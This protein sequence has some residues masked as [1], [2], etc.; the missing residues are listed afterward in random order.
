MVL[1]VGAVLIIGGGAWRSVQLWRGATADLDSWPAGIL[2]AFPVMS[3]MFAL[4]L[5]SAA[6]SALFGEGEDRG[7]VA[8]VFGLVSAFA[9]VFGTALTVKA[10]ITGRPSALVPPHLRSKRR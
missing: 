3:A 10:A 7:L 9:L 2:R 5:G 4:F 8:T 6:L 1:A